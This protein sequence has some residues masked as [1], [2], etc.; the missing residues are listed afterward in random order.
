MSLLLLFGGAHVASVAPV[1]PLDARGRVTADSAAPG[2]A[3]LLRAGA[4]AGG[5]GAPRSFSRTSA[6]GARGGATSGSAE[7]GVE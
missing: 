3:A 2:V 5:P 4:A 6:P 1:I 7:G